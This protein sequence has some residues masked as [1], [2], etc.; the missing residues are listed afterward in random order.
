[1]TLLH[2]NIHLR[3]KEL[4]NSFEAQSQESQ[5][6]VLLLVGIQKVVYSSL[7]API[8]YVKILSLALS[9]SL[10]HSCET[11]VWDFFLSL[12]KMK[13][14]VFFFFWFL[15]NVGLRCHFQIVDDVTKIMGMFYD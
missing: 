6:M 14:E 3:G 7:F 1:M 12:F 9:L 8:S 11:L 15:D 4:N 13:V 10:S 5:S 2:F